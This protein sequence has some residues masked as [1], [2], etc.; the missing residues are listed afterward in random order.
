MSDEGTRRVTVER[1]IA[2]PPETIFEVLA[3]PTQHAAIDGSGTV[4]AARA[5]DP[6]RLSAGATFGMDMRLG[7]PYRITNTVV[8]FD[9]GRRIA[10]R[11]MGGHVWRY[12]LE[13][14]EGGTRVVETFDY[15]TNRAPWLLELLRVPDRNR[16]GMVRT[17]ERL[18]AH[19]TAA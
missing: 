9:E 2:A 12:E 14:V 5:G 8:E 17:L 7:V 19:V 1:V 6:A 15:A 18:D 13:P 11:H 3:D 16:Q 4:K 10:W